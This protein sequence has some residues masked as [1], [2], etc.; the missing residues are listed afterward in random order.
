VTELSMNTPAIPAAKALVR[1]LSRA[2]SQA[3]AERALALPT[4][5]AVRAAITE[6]GPARP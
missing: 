1:G 3:L 6:W 2:E 5:A 4:A